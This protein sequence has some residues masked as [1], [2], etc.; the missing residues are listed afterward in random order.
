M[1]FI[2]VIPARKGSISIKNK[3]IIKIKNKPLIEYT[4]DQINRSKLSSKDSYVITNDSRVKKIAK[5]NNINTDYVR[6]NILSSSKTPLLENLK[7]FVK[8][9]DNSGI[10]YDYLV[11]LQPT[12]PLRKFIDINKSIE[13]VIKKK[14]KCLVSLSESLEHPYE[15]VFLNKKNRINFFLKNGIKYTR[16]QDFDRRSYFVNGAIYITSKEL[17]KKNKIIDYS[18]S[19]F[20]IMDKINSLDLNDYS[21]LNLIKSLLSQ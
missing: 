1:K 3:N 2:S 7:H 13:I 8:W 6:S 16:R 11:V 15:S 9:A 10:K 19:D 20:T 21:E 5:K 18:K 14:S 12:S 4:F 17:I